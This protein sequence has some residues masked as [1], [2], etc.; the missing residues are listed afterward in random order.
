MDYTVRRAKYVLDYIVEFTFADGSV[1]EI[2]F[3]P[4]LWGPVSEPLKDKEYFHNF[5]IRYGTITWPN[6][7]DVAPETL[8]SGVWPTRE[9]QP[10]S[11]GSA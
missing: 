8:H 1:R 11:R 6:G 5:R 2:D 7:A 9:E 4:H 10:A 3:E